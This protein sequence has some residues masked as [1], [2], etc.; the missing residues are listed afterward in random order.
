MP[1][2]PARLAH[3]TPAKVRGRFR[4]LPTFG[5][6]LLLDNAELGAASVLFPA[7]RQSFGV[8]LSALGLLGGAAKLVSVV[9]G[10]LWVWLAGRTSRKGVLVVTCGL[11]S[12]WGVA[13]GFADSFGQLL[14]LY[15]V[16]AAG[17][18]GTEPIVNAILADLFDGRARG[19]AVGCLYGSIALGS[20]VIMPAIGQLSRIHDGWRVAFWTLGSIG[21]LLGLLVLIFFRDPGIGAAEQK[22]ARNA[23]NAPFRSV[24][25][26][27]GAFMA[28]LRIR[29]FRL[30]LCSRLLSGHLL[31][32]SFGVVFLVEVHHFSNAVAALVILPFG[33]GYFCGSITGG[34]VGDWL[35]LRRPRSGRIIV[36]QSAQ[37]LFA[38]AAFLATQFPWHGI[39]TF[40]VFFAAMGF[41]QGVNPAVN[42]PIVMAVVPPELR[43]AAFAIFISLFDGLTWAAYQF[44]AG[45]LGDRIGLQAVF[46]IILVGFML[47][48]ATL[49]T[50][51]YRTYPDDSDSIGGRVDPRR[52]RST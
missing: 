16:L 45:Y 15:L 5:G 19:R 39:T 52:S 13:A 23:M 50:L 17:Y 32:L 47:L 20:A 31:I 40:G 38:V 48:N 29:S 7:I 42:R 25:D 33:I 18:A 49:I 12:G 1:I 21:V 46:L 36:L 4:A 24:G 27:N 22:P 11:W 10:P 35:D 14:L 9:F 44:A 37:A 34:T 3:P 6:V 51:L 43:A 28:L 8:S 30:M 41:L 26:L 2:T